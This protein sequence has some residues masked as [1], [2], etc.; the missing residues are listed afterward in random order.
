MN[1]KVRA[2]RGLIGNREHDHLFQAIFW[3]SIWRKKANLY[4]WQKHSPKNIT[5]QRS[6]SIRKKGEKVKLPRDQ[7]IHALHY[8]LP[9]KAVIN[10]NGSVTIMECLLVP[11]FQKKKWS[12][13]MLLERGKLETPN[14]NSRSKA[15]NQQ[16]TQ[17]TNSTGWICDSNPRPACWKG[18]C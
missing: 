9:Y 16:R 12:I 1:Q 4:D 11:Y 5:K 6:C 18:M 10:S 13:E 15:R 17:P 8:C 2:P 3:E 14:K 7:R